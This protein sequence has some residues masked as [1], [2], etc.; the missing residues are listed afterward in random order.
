[1][2][3]YKLIFY[4]QELRVK[5]NIVALVAAVGMMLLSL[6]IPWF[7]LPINL[8]I[9]VGLLIAVIGFGIVQS[10]KTSF[11]KAHTSDDPLKPRLTSTLIT[12]GT[13]RFSRNPM[14]V[15]M[16]F[17]LLG[18]AIFLM[19]FLAFVLL[20]AYIFYI[21]RFQIIPEERA[22]SAIFGP[23]YDS[24]YANVHKWL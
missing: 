21:N 13:Y 20:I 14:Y 1:M 9:Y 10:A 24:Y 5:P 19:N 4:K 8:P 6:V 18:W 12:A 2:R 15:G 17:I 16:I 23:K 3:N 22:L 7:D 11:R